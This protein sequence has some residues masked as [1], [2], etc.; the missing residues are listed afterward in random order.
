ME[1]SVIRANIV[2][3]E[4]HDTVTRG[5]VRDCHRPDGGLVAQEIFALQTLRVW[6]QE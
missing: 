2:A 1:F 3:G 5:L 4:D 6:Q